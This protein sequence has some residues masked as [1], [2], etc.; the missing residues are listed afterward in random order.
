M[1]T[2]A[3]VQARKWT[4]ARIRTVTLTAVAVLL[5][6]FAIA[7]C[8]SGGERQ[9]ANAQTGT[10]KVA[11]EQWEFPAVQPLGRPVTMKLVIRNIDTRD[12]PTVVVSIGGLR[13]PVQQQGSATRTRP[14]WIVNEVREGDQTP[15]NS[16]TK[17]SYD[18]G[19]LEPGEVR[20]FELPLTPLRR[21]EH[22]VSYTL[23]AGLFGGAKLETVDGDP[24]AGSRT[25]A[26]DPNP[27]FD[28]SA[29]D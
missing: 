19:A 12:I 24:A 15:Y 22:V 9:D 7:G 5:T 21:G 29:F 4:V 16:L 28:E 11:V 6:T 17:T 20:T 26:I 8:G 13:E 1:G 23:A 14:I 10:W 2:Q 25:V 3:A 18:T 27:D